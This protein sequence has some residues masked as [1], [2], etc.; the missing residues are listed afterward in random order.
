MGNNKLIVKKDTFFSKIKWYIIS[1]FKRKEK[2]EEITPEITQKS[3]SSFIQ[4]LRSDY[5][6]D[7]NLVKLQQKFEAGEI[8]E[9][10]LT[11]EEVNELYDFYEKQIEELKL[12]LKDQETQLM[13][14]DSLNND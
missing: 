10:D 14:L 13:R 11:D 4:S 8:T 12:K 2:E 3:E 6:Q 1:L 7:E 5:V 9:Q